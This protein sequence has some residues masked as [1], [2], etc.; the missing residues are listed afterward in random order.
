MGLRN[1]VYTIN[2][3]VILGGVYMDRSREDEENMSTQ[4]QEAQKTN[5][6]SNADVMKIAKK[7]PANTEKR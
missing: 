5:V 4:H 7:V 1:G 3:E 6:L 2:Q